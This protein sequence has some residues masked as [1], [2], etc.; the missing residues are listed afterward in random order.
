[1]KISLEKQH[2][3]FTI[4]R[5]SF[6]NNVFIYSYYYYSEFEI[7]LIPSFKFNDKQPRAI[8]GPH[9]HPFRHVGPEVSLEILLT[10]PSEFIRLFAKEKIL[11]RDL[12]SS[13]QR[14][15]LDE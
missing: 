6:P 11:E 13:H 7:F 10:H 9:A 1:M 12:A 4:V 5:D 15:K 2:K 14:S 3:L 8:Q